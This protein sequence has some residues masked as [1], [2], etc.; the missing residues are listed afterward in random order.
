MRKPKAHIAK[1]IG[2]TDSLRD[3]MEESD[4]LD[5]FCKECEDGYCD[6][7]FVTVKPVTEGQARLACKWFE[8]TGIPPMDGWWGGMWGDWPCFTAMIGK[9]GN[10]YLVLATCENK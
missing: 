9:D 10:I 5:M 6:D 7:I 8:A 3:L 4:H 1:A 2:Y